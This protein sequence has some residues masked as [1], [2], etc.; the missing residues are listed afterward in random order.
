MESFLQN[1]CYCQIVRIVSLLI[2]F[3]LKLDLM[4]QCIFQN[5]KILYPMATIDDLYIIYFKLND[6]E[7]NLRRRVVRRH[8]IK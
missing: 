7:E 8:I 5:C 6:I 4:E 2:Y 1:E 3:D